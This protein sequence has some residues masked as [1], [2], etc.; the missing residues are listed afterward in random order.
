MTKFLRNA[1]RSATSFQKTFGPWSLVTGASSGIG[2]EF[3]RLLA[4]QGLNVVVA[5]RRKS[6][7]EALAAELRDRFE[8]E[9]RT[10]VVDLAFEEAVGL[11]EQ[12]VLDLDVG[13]VV[14]NAGTGAPGRFLRQDHAEQLERFRLNALAHL[15]IAYAFGRRLERR[16]GGVLILGGA[17]GAAHGI[18]F[19]AADAGAKALVQSL[20]ESLH[21]ELKDQGIQV[22]TLIVPPTDTAIIAKFGLDPSQMP[23]KPMSAE[24][25]ASEALRDFRKG[26]SISL[27][28]RANRVMSAIVPVPLARIMM[29]TMIRR[30][31]PT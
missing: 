26:R 31:L 11:L 20:G 27:P 4:A 19:M 2:S 29:G 18:P 24:Q 28:G 15:N 14:S 22:M 6:L 1:Y 10:V 30:T 12:A 16:G 3:A 23:M 13:L 17:M 21:L 5:A 7:L 25:C 9:S 8:V